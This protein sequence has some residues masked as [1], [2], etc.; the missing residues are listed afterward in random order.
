MPK[1]KALIFYGEEEL[2][3]SGIGKPIREPYVAPD[4]PGIIKE[5]DGTNAR[6]SFNPPK[7]G[8]IQAAPPDNRIPPIVE[9]SMWNGWSGKVAV[10]VQAG[11]DIATGDAAVL[12][13][14]QVET[15]VVTPNS[16]IYK[17]GPFN[18]EVFV[19]PRIKG[20]LTVISASGNILTL[21]FTG[22]TTQYHFDVQTDAF[23]D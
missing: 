12:V 10:S 21:Q 15:Q 4:A 7:T 20:D 23:V 6:V 9:T 8:E 22:N 17:P 18:G 11:T 19:S 1:G 3:A 16:G 14:T 2:A 13:T 5:P